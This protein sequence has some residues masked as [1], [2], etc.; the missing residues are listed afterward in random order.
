MA[1]QEGGTTV[2]EA[3][4]EVTDNKSID[5]DLDISV[6]F[7]KQVVSSETFKQKDCVSSINYNAFNISL[8]KQTYLCNI[9]DFWTSRLKFLART[10]YL[11]FN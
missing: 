6:A 8:G 4:N 5:D 9:N 2:T 10:N 1:Y 11:P 3:D 7:V